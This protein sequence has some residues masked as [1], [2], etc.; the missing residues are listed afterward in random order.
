MCAPPDFTPRKPKLVLPPLACDTHAHIL[1]PA[2]RYAYSAARVYTPPDCLLPDY[3]HM[4]K[5]LGVERAVLVQPSVYGT[6]NTAMLD[7]M[8]AAGN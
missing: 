5:T 1:G 7:A 2:A 8:K 6:D 4:L 3:Q